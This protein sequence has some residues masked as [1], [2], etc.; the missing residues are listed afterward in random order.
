MRNGFYTWSQSKISFLSFL[1]IGSKWTFLGWSDRWLPTIRIFRNT[2]IHD[3]ANR[4]KVLIWQRKPFRLLPLIRQAP[5]TTSIFITFEFFFD[6]EGSSKLTSF[7]KSN[8]ARYEM[9]RR[10][11]ASYKSTKMAKKSYHLNP[12]CIASNNCV[13]LICLESNQFLWN[14]MTSTMFMNAVYLLGAGSP[15]L[16]TRFQL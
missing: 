14:A 7:S 8:V 5:F 16:T 6:Q 12:R 2:Q 4:D 1:V 3:R 15:H 13:I 10:H 11:S 9:F